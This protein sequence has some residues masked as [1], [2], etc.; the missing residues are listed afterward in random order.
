M[1]FF[2]FLPYPRENA[3][4]SQAGAFPISK[5]DQGLLSI[6][7]ARCPVHKAKRHPSEI[8]SEKCPLF[9][10]FRSYFEFSV[11]YLNFCSLSEFPLFIRISVPYFS[12]QMSLL[13]SMMVLSDEKKPAFA[14]LTS[15]IFCHFL[16]FS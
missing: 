6:R 2:S 5:M 8:F 4:P 16:R 11:L 9:L 3:L 12:F 14:M 15:I 1:K 10:N 7:N 13:Y